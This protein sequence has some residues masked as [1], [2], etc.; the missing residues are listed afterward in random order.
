M[1]LKQS[2]F[3]LSAAIGPSGLERPAVE[4]AQ[5]LLAPLVDETQIDAVGNLTGLRRCGKP[6]AK[7]V[8]LDA[9]LDEVALVVTGQKDGY[10][11]FACLGIDSRLLPASTVQVLTAPPMAGVITCLP[12]HVLTA[13]EKEQPFDVDKLYIDCG[14]TEEQAKAVPVGTRVVYDTE[15]IALQ[16]DVVCGKS[17]DN[18]AGFCVLLRAMELLQH[19]TLPVDVVV[20]GSVQEEYS[21][22]GA[23]TGAFSQMPDRAIVVDVTFAHQ[24]DAPKSSTV[25]MGC[26]AI[27][28]GPHLHRSISGKLRQLAPEARVEVLSAGTGT[29]ASA[30]Q[31]S[32]EGVPTG[33]ISLP[34]RYMHTPVEVVR[35][36]DID[37]CAQLI[38]D[39]IISLGEE[40]C[41]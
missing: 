25:P 32:R 7:R 39:W 29:N 18:R 10:L 38:A 17:L 23:K 41:Q 35:L 1:D 13:A 31:I 16:G 6:E 34:L 30:L 9:H 3:T 2:L 36:G 27:G 19:K 15:P 8:L 12:P 28:V 21:M 22:L 14:M 20:L 33:L 26:P 11:S 37:A 4:A 5:V 24:P 40:D